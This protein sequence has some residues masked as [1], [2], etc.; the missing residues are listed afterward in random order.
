MAEQLHLLTQEY[1]VPLLIN[2][3]ADVA[4]AVGA[5]GVHLGQDDMGAY[6]GFH[7]LFKR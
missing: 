5:E 4:L 1:K 7:P 6:K 3:R 2:D